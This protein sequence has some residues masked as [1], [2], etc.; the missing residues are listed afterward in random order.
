MPTAAE[1]SIWS[2]QY[3]E[4]RADLKEI[5][6]RT[7]APCNECGLATIDWDGPANQPDSFELDHKIS[8]KRALAMNRPDLLLAP[9]NMAPTH[10]RCNRAKG[11]GDSTPP[12]GEMSEDY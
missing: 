12:L 5:W 1:S 7:N 9:S 10:H 11:A 3:K 6:Q 4:L 8:R 2:R